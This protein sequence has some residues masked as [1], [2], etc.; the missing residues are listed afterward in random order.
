MLRL[1]DIVMP[2]TRSGIAALLPGS[3]WCD[4]FGDA[5][6]VFGFTIPGWPGCW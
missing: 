1:I 3:N 2:A 5:W 6:H 4:R